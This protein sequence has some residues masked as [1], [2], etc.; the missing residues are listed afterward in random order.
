[1]ASYLKVSRAVVFGGVSLGKQIDILRGGV[2]VLV[3]TPGRLVDLIER[4][5]LTL[6]Q[7][8]DLRARRSRPDA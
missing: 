8:R 5:A 4:K 1:M 2:D 6:S 7:G 3:A